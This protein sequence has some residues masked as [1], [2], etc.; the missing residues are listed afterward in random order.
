MYKKNTNFYHK[1]CPSCGENYNMQDSK[2][3]KCNKVLVTKMKTDSNIEIKICPSCNS[4]IAKIETKCPV[5]TRI[6]VI[7]EEKKKR[8]SLNEILRNK[9]IEKV[10]SYLRT[11]S[12]D[13]YA[14][15]KS[16]TNK[17]V[18][19]YL[20]VFAIGS[21]PFLI[22]SNAQSKKVSLLENEIKLLK[23]TND[24]LNITI[25]SNSKKIK[26]MQIEN[27]SLKKSLDESKLW[28]ELSEKRQKQLKRE[29]ERN[30]K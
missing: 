22:Y 6:L 29:I 28:F 16:T 9:H 12:K 14:T 24:E 21:T 17:H 27:N 19:L 20:C 1:E 4:N 2:C 10:K 5:C 30:K 11:F 15:L 8:V 25:S 23:N 26:E 13:L 7:D 18:F 3:S